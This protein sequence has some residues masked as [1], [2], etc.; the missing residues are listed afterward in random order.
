MLAWV[1]LRAVIADLHVGQEQGDLE[2][3]T[4]LTADLARRAPGEVVFLGDLFRTLVGYSG[5]WDETIRGGLEAMR[6]LRGSGARVVL[7]E[8]NRDF[9]LDVPELDPYRDT[10]VIAHSFCAGGRRFLLEHGDLINRRDRSYRLWRSLSKSR[11]ARLWA[12][13][14]PAA[15]AIRIVSG[16]EA[17]L[18][19]TNFSYRRHLPADDL[20]AAARR[21]FAAGVDVVMWGHFHRAWRIEAG[22]RTAMVLPSWAETGAV[23]WVDDAGEVREERLDDSG[24]FVDSA[25]QSWY[26]EDEGL[27][28]VR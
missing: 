12:R 18:A 10:S 4:A 8:G 9:F 5:Y 3:F 14:L 6:E 11:A 23:V 1:M 25:Q 17:R 22:G 26:Q 19:R 27:V 7:V 21:H 2:R 24:Y 16:T 13:L 20:A 28:E 15:I